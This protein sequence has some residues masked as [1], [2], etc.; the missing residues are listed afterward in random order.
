MTDSE[1]SG[2]TFG[3]VSLTPAGGH[4]AILSLNAPERRN[5][6]TPSLACQIVAAVEAA[7]GNDECR[8]IVLAGSGPAFCAGAELSELDKASA[9]DSEAVLRSIYDAFLRVRSSTLPTV[10]AVAGPAVG[11]GLNLAMACDMRIAG[12]GARFDSRFL[13]LGLHP[14]GGASWMLNAA[15]GM[16]TTSAMLL[17]GEVVDGI[18]AERLGLAWKCVDDDEVLPCAVALAG[19]AARAPK[20]LSARIK[21]TLNDAARAPTHA[22]ALEVEFERQVWSFRQPWFTQRRA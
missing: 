14:G 19:Q 21:A 17:F 8:A 2:A 7:E 1:P 3:E 12:R 5:A 13:R 11:A 22:Q 18:A 16:P 6:I 9:S 20:E 4:V 10:A 15:V